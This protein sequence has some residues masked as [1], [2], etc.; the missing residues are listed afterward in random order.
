[1]NVPSPGLSRSDEERSIRPATVVESVLASLRKLLLTGELQPNQ[2]IKQGDLAERL[3]VSPVPVREALQVL[4]SEGLVTYSPGRGFRVTELS[5][6]EVE[7]IDLLAR[8]LEKEAFKRGVPRLTDEDIAQMESLFEELLNLEGTN[9][10]WRQLHIHREFHFIPVRA[11]GL[12]R[13][14]SELTRFWEHTDHHRVV[15]VFKKPGT[16]KIALVQHAQI[17]EACRT[18]DPDIV[19]KVMQEHRDYALENILENVRVKE[20]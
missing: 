10:V 15:Y 8:I 5:T 18:R 1:V 3:G 17:I 20:A 16:S 2:R 12:P 11:A 7:E 4:Q 13:L 19:M 9:D 14:T 6:E